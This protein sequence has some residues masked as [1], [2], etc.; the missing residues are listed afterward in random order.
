MFWVLFLRVRITILAGDFSNLLLDGNLHGPTL[1]PT[2]N[3]GHEYGLLALHF[4]GLRLPVYRTSLG[5]GAG[6]QLVSRHHVP[7]FPLSHTFQQIL[8]DLVQAGIFSLIGGHGRVDFA[9]L[10]VA[11]EEL[12]SQ[13]DG[14]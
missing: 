6:I 10:G 5:L 2:S 7:S 8:V 14:R 4:F 13:W 3:T 1:L 12:G 11:G 9:S